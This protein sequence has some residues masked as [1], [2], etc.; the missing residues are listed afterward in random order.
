MKVLITAG[1]TKTMIDQVRCITNVFKGRTGADMA[2]YFGAN[3]HYVDL[4]TSNTDIKLMNNVMVLPHYKTYDDLFESMKKFITMKKYDVIIHSAAVS[5]Y[6][7]DGIFKPDMSSGELELECVSSATKVSSDH[8][9]LYIKMIPTEKIIDKIRSEWGFE[10]TLVKFKLQV[11][12]KDKELISVAQES[13][14]ASN[15][16]IIVANCLEWARERAYICDDNGHLNV[17]RCN[18]SKKLLEKIS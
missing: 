10:G 2:E 8:D 9:E 15:A 3:G 7:P 6:K 17:K 5:D 16:D 1:S 14:K 11:D 4:L 13:R 18:L 12:M